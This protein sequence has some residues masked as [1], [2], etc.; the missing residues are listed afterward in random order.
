MEQQA[1][2]LQ[3]AKA[4]TER[5]EAE[6]LVEVA[7]WLRVLV[8]AL[9]TKSLRLISVGHD[10]PRYFQIQ[11]MPLENRILITDLIKLLRRYCS[12]PVLATASFRTLVF[13]LIVATNAGIA[14]FESSG[15]FSFFCALVVAIQNIGG[16][17]GCHVHP[18]TIVI[19]VGP[20][21]YC[22]LK[23]RHTANRHFSGLKS[24]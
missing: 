9:T 13:I 14:Y 20:F 23:C 22:H 18:T 17:T 10:S 7:D 15:A 8:R 12:K 1:D 19:S 2:C 16:S 3:L 6:S 21:F 5:N 24:W 11:K 4:H